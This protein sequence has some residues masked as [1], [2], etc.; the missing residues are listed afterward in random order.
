MFF[1]LDLPGG[2]GQ[3]H[4]QKFVKI[5]KLLENDSNSNMLAAREDLL[6]VILHPFQDLDVQLLSQ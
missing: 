3:A 5:T 2:S 1:A 4:D 6:D